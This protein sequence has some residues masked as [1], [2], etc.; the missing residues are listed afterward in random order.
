MEKNVGVNQSAGDYMENAKKLDEAMNSPETPKVPTEPGNN[1]GPTSD[2][3]T[4]RGK[5]DFNGDGSYASGMKET[6]EK[7]GA[8]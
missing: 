5:P 4:E 2:G 7:E 3:G 6:K 8:K 1:G